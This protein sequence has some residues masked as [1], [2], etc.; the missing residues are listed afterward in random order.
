GRDLDLS[1]AHQDAIRFEIGS[2]DGNFRLGFRGHMQQ[3]L[4]FSQDLEHNRSNIDMNLRRARFTFFG[5]MFSPRISYLIQ[6]GLESGDKDP[7]QN[8]G[9]S[10]D[11]LNTYYVKGTSHLRDYYI[12]THIHNQV[13]VRIGKF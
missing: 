13:Q 11:N 8:V 6:L 3:K 1:A 12:N 7:W 9:I 4:E 5:T 2:P 10:S